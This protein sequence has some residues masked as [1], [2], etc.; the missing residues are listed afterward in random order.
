MKEIWKDVC[1]YENYYQISNYGQV[2][3]K[4]SN[5]ILKN[6]RKPNGYLYVSLYANK[7]SSKKY[8]HRLV[9]EAFLSNDLKLAQV[10]HIDGNKKN[11]I[12]TNLEWCTQQENLLHAKNNNLINPTIENL[13]HDSKP[14]LRIEDYK[15][16]KNVKAAALDMKVTDSAIRKAILK[17]PQATSCGFHWKYLSK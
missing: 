17:G 3:R 1:G 6:Q 13:K 5:Y 9:A 2:K 15:I 14:V 12:V 7:I 8:I 4:D 10:N 11:N 16:Y